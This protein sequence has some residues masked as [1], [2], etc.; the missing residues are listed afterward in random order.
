ML[1]TTHSNYLLQHCVKY[2][3]DEFLSSAFN[4]FLHLPEPDLAEV[5]TGR[6]SNF[7][8]RTFLEIGRRVSSLTLLLC[9]AVH[10]HLAE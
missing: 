7:V 6:F 1:A 4:S 2:G 10:I 9:V 8:V 3:T 5:V